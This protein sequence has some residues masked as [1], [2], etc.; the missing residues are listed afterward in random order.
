MPSTNKRAIAWERNY[1]LLQEFIAEHGRFPKHREAYKG[2]NLGHWCL[3]QK[4]NAQS[5][6]CDPERK[7]K[8][9]AIGLLN[10]PKRFTWEQ[11]KEATPSFTEEHG[12]LPEQSETY[13]GENIGA[14]EDPRKVMYE[15]HWDENLQLAIQFYEEYGRF[16]KGNEEFQGVKI[17]YWCVKQRMAAK[18]PHYPPNRRLKLQSA[19]FFDA[20]ALRK[21]QDWEEKFQVLQSFIQDYGRPPKPEEIYQGERIGYWYLVQCRNAKNVP[22]YPEE[23]RKRLRSLGAM[24]RRRIAE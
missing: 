14:L 4:Q 7:E 22:N 23:Y 8:L 16:P 12:R 17:G 24:C 5:P 1:Q 3:S 20:D 13:N 10:H 11:Y 15:Q 9:E 21:A 18:K 6:S 2:V 19:G